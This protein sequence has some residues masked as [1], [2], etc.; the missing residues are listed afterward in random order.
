LAF[1]FFRMIEAG[2]EI[3]VAVAS[4]DGATV[5]E[6]FGKARRFLVYAYRGE[7]WQLVETRANFPAC[8]GQ[9]HSD[10]FLE[11][12][13]DLLGDCRGVVVSQIGPGAMDTLLHRKILPFSLNETI[14]DALAIVLNSKLFRIRCKL[15]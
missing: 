14:A 3:K 8:A 5:N 6:H 11:Q 2:M 7:E 12:T 15:A 10:D 1:L 9:Q 4:S 13:A